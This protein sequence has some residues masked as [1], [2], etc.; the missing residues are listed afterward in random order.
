MPIQKKTKIYCRGGCLAEEPHTYLLWGKLSHEQPKILGLP[1]VFLK[2]FTPNCMHSSIKL[3]YITN[4]KHPKVSTYHAAPNLVLLW[5]KFKQRIVVT[6]KS[7]ARNN[8]KKGLLWNWKHWFTSP[9]W[10][11]WLS[12]RRI[13]SK[14]KSKLEGCIKNN[15]L[16]MFSKI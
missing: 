6:E 11:F 7:H 12:M 5:K 3:K 15:C 13:D 2:Y 16:L 4:E 8:C 9:R 10:W 1:I 14:I